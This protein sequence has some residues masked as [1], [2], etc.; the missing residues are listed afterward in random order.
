MMS[1][2]VETVVL[3]CID[4]FR[5]ERTVN[6]IYYLI[7]GKKSA[8]TIQDVV[9]FRLHRYYNILP[10]FDKNAFFTLLHKMER[11]DQIVIE[12][13]IARI[14]AQGKNIYKKYREKYP[15]PDSFDGYRFQHIDEQFWKRLS[16]AVQVLSHWSYNKTR[17]IPVQKEPEIQQEVK[18]WLFAAGKRYSKEEIAV[19]FY[20]ELLRLLQLVEEYDLAPELIVYRLTGYKKA[21]LTFRQLAQKMHLDEDYCQVLFR[22]FLHQVI[23]L[24]WK[25]SDSFPLL[26]SLVQD[27]HQPLILTRSSARTL[28]LLR[29][30]KTITDIARIRKLRPGTVQDHVVEIAF[31]DPQFSIDPFVRPE[32]QEKINAAVSKSNSRKLRQIKELVTEADYFSIRLVLASRMKTK[33]FQDSW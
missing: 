10:G 29:M 18:H 25:R 32:L 11:Q 16:L 33:T 22:A 4:T 26:A 3:D 15:W 9:W 2:F 17:F 6:A 30:G 23:S 14:T 20:E 19:L 5:A 28:E 13:E 27:L 21:G 12:K 24:L 8:Q 31:M 1:M 7:T